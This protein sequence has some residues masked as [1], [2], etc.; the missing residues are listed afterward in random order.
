D[1]EDE[2]ELAAASTRR[3]EHLHQV[4]ARVPKSREFT[5]FGVVTSE[6]DCRNLGFPRSDTAG[7]DDWRSA[8]RRCTAT[9]ARLQPERLEQLAELDA[10]GVR[11]LAPFAESVRRCFAAEHV[12]DLLA[13]L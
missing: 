9:R 10:I 12:P 2:R 7:H 3:P 11:H 6:L 13:D 5:R 1:L 8:H 4:R